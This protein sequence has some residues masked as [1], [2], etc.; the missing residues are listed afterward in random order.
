MWAACWDIQK[1]VL[2]VRRSVDYSAEQLAAKKAGQ[3]DGRKAAQRVGQKAAE[4]VAVM[5]AGL[6]DY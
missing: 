1:A 6:V 2:T 3:M 5:V 4:T